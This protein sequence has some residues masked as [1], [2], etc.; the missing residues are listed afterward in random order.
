MVNYCLES[1]LKSV[2]LTAL[3]FIRSYLAIP[4]S[5]WVDDFIDWLNPQSRC[6]RLYT[7]GPNL[8]NFCPATE[9]VYHLAAHTGITHSGWA[10]SRAG[11]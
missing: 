2:Y 11:V 6:C 10:H 5:S 3:I 4:A 1:R 7:I 8:G 9:S